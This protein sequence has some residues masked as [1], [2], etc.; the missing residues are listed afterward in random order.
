[1]SRKPLF[2]EFSKGLIEL[3]DVKDNAD[4]SDE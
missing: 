2:E 1:M 4:D 3:F